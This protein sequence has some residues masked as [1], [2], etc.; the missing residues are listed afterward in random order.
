[1][2]NLKWLLVKSLTR[3][4]EK[5]LP[6]SRS[7]ASNPYNF[8]TSKS[9]LILLLG[10]LLSFVFFATLYCL[11]FSL[12][13]QSLPLLSSK[14]WLRLGAFLIHGIFFGKFILRLIVG[15]INIC[16]RSLHL[17]VLIILFLLSEI[18]FSLLMITSSLI[19]LFL[20]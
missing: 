20:T 9:S 16:S 7:L 14:L 10:L 19:F 13:L 3:S 4:L 15:L 5:Y 12:I 11:F 2:E 1:M 17:T 8:L 18:L 6:R